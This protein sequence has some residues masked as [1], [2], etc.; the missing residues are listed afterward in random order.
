MNETE[1]VRLDVREAQGVATGRGV[2]RRAFVGM[3]CALLAGFALPSVGRAA[4][5][6]A[7]SEKS[8]S[9]SDG[10]AASFT[11]PLDDARDNGDGTITIHDMAGREVTIPKQVK[12]VMGAAN[13]DG[14]IIYSINPSLLTGWTFDLSDDAKKYLTQEAAALPKITSVSK[15][16]DPNKEEI[17][18]MAPDV[19]SVAVDL[20]N[21]DL[22]LYD[23]LTAEVGVPIV[24]VDAELAHL[25]NTYRF[26]GEILGEQGQCEKLAG[27]I[28]QTFDDVSAT[29]EGVSDAD[30]VR[31]LYSTGDAGTQ[32]CGDSNWNGQFVTP[33]GG[34]NVCDTDQTSG[35]ADVSMEQVLG[36]Q[37]DVIISTATGD[38][39]SI[40]SAQEW[41]DVKAVQQDQVY[42]APKYPFSWVDKPTG[43]NRII[44][45]KWTNSILY[46]DK[47]DYD[48][49]EAVSEFYDLFYHYELG[50]DEVDQL[51]DTHVELA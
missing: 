36:W 28:D 8:S 50:D 22:S 40:Y 46:P 43:A 38:K 23:D 39:S 18:R 25:A 30:R 13:P 9:S 3:G 51:L 11:S 20:T 48:I 5:A 12:T 35:F 29:M 14:I 47:A 34:V 37:P 16:E 10:S 41:A 24:V 44:G 21:V 32:T 2:S 45:V 7:A 4:G 6:S 33:A 17:L 1:E 31:V 15:W 26:L 19:I 49:R 27:F 42:A